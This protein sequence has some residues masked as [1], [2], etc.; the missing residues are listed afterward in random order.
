MHFA[1]A[2]NVPE[3]MELLIKHGGDPKMKESHGVTVLHAAAKLG[4]KEIFKW[5]VEKSCVSLL[6][7]EAY[8]SRGRKAGKGN[9]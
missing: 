6:V 5:L 3:T 7:S 4:K 8:E 1:V 9:N 2:E